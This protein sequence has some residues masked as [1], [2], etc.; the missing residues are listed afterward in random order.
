MNKNEN[1]FNDDQNSPFDENGEKGFEM[2]LHYFDSFES[3]LRQKL[4]IENELQEFSILNSIKK[5]NTFTV[6]I[7]YFNSIE[8][9]LDF[10]TEL[11]D[12]PLLQFVKSKSSFLVDDEYQELFE[13]KLN[14][15]IGNIDE[16]KEYVTL[17]LIEKQNNFSYPNTYF[18]N[19]SSVIKEKIYDIKPSGFRN[20]FH[21]IFDKKM[22][23]SFSAITII[24]LSLIFYPKNNTEAVIDINCKTLA[25]LEKQEILN[26]TKTISSFDEDQLIELVNI[27]KLNDQLNSTKKT[28]AENLENDSFTNTS[29]LDDIID[30]L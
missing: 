10:K 17:Y 21:F 22:A 16:L 1:N 13:N 12:F 29:N 5:T 6:P 20:F 25:C 2:P 3:K 27:K 24:V 26:N 11:V 18:E 14:E 28:D 19:L 30:E 8:D 9:R 7:E 4:E 23:L 15:K